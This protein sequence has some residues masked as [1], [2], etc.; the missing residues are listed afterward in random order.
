MPSL[1]RSNSLLQFETLEK[2]CQD[3]NIYN[4]SPSILSTFS[5]DSLENQQ[6][7]PSLSPDSLSKDSDL[8]DEY[9]RLISIDGKKMSK[10]IS[11]ENLSEDSGYSEFRAFDGEICST[12]QTASYFG[13]SYHDLSIFDPNKIS[14]KDNLKKFSR[15][16]KKRTETLLEIVEESN[17]NLESTEGTIVKNSIASQQQSSHSTSVPNLLCALPDR[18][19]SP[20]ELFSSVP[21]LNFVGVVKCAGDVETVSAK[22]YDLCDLSTIGNMGDI[23]NDNN[24]IIIRLKGDEPR[25]N[26]REGKLLLNAIFFLIHVLFLTFLLSLCRHDTNGEAPNA[27]AYLNSVSREAGLYSKDYIHI[28]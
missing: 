25:P 24:T 3:E 21:N 4:S 17:L 19:H 5:Y 9:Y 7:K 14:L 20:I 10:K 28:K 6:S 16:F 12:N 22:N 1:S 15:K 11:T 8:D 2:R 13:T 26:E 27:V 18:R 23:S